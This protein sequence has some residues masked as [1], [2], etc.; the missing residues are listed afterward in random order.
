MALNYFLVAMYE[1]ME[2][3]QRTEDERAGRALIHEGTPDICQTLDWN[4]PALANFIAK[5][6]A[7]DGPIRIASSTADTLQPVAAMSAMQF[8][9]VTEANSWLASPAGNN[10]KTGAVAIYAF[11]TRQAQDA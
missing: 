6:G 2:V 5:L 1:S 10:F 7:I 4:S 9:T 11:G 3:T 8:A